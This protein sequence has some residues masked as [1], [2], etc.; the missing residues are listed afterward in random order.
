M[1]TEKAQKNA[2]DCFFCSDGVPAA[3]VEAITISEPFQAIDRITHV[4]VPLRRPARC[5]PSANAEQ[6]F[7]DAQAAHRALLDA[8]ELTQYMEFRREIGM[9]D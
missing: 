7:L 1:I 6:D 9:D 5:C 3:N 4:S 2:A 8:N